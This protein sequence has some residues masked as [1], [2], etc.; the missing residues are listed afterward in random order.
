MGDTSVAN[1]LDSSIGEMIP[2]M[3]TGQSSHQQ[4]QQQLNPNNMLQIQRREKELDEKEQD[5]KRKLNHIEKQ[6]KEIIDYSKEL[7][8]KEE[9]LK[10]K[11]PTL[12]VS[13]GKRE[14]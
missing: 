9:E 4:Q 1:S 14:S 5:I 2:D 11:W 3:T 8:E 7:E 12:W 13:I 10:R 6:E